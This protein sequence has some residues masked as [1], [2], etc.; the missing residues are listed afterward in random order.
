M[1]RFISEIFK[2]KAEYICEYFDSS[3]L[4]SYLPPSEQELPEAVKAVAILKNDKLRD[5]IL[6]IESDIT[7]NESDKKARHIEAVTSIHTII[8]QAFEVVSKQPALLNLYRQMITSIV[9]CLSNARQYESVLS[10]CFD[11]IAQEFDTPDTPIVKQPNP[12][13]LALQMQNQR[14]LWDYEIKKEQNEIKKTELMLKKQQ[15]EAKNKL[16]L[17]ELSLQAIKKTTEK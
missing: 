17:D 11:K 9:S 6:G 12:Q 4:L 2:I 3:K 7:F 16:A 5:M 10:Q 13:L 15:D 8:A 14:N 1:N